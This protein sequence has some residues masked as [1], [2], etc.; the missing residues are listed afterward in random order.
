MLKLILLSLGLNLL[1]LT[2]KGMAQGNHAFDGSSSFLPLAP[3]V[4]KLYVRRFQ[5]YLNNPI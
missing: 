2:V 5:E 3:I 4:D 1:V